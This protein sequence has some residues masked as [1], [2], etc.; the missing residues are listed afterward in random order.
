[1]FVL[2]L[3]SIPVFFIVHGNVKLVSH[4]NSRYRGKQVIELHNN[5]INLILDA[6]M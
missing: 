3:F 5:G 4:T 1:M 2:W 6:C